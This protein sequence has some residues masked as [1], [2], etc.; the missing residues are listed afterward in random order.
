[1]EQYR[2]GGRISIYTGLPTILGW[3]WHQTQQRFAYREQVDERSS[4]VRRVYETTD[5]DIAV[6]LMRRYGVSYVVVGDLER[7]NYG[8]AG[9]AKFE[10]MEEEGLLS[11]VYAN[12]KTAIF[13]TEFP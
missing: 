5:A 3:P 9:L 12:E 1:M 2:W 13:R 11:K 4:H 7:L 6:G 10:R 8:A